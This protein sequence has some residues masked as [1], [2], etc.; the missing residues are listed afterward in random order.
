MDLNDVFDSPMNFKLTYHCVNGIE[1]STV[2]FE[3]LNDVRVKLSDD[4]ALLNKLYK[5]N[6]DQYI[7]FKDDHFTAELLMDT[8]NEILLKSEVKVLVKSISIER[9]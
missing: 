8:F 4:I 1:D 2:Y 5:S 7:L 9:I 6:I 3:T